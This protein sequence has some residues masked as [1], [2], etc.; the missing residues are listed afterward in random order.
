M[1][2]KDE[3]QSIYF[4]LDLF[5]YIDATFKKR[6]SQIFIVVI[7]LGTCY[8]INLRGKRRGEQAKNKPG[9]LKI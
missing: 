1:P 9:Q 8:V 2:G 5:F 6:L 4:T 3:Y 7:A